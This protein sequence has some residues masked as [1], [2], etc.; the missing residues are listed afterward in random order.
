MS[1]DLLAMV[2]GADRKAY[3]G[4]LLAPAQARDDLT[5]L[6]A[7][8]VELARI[9]L[10]VTEP[11]AGE[12][13][14]QW[15]ADVIRGGRDAESAGHPVAS[16]VLAAIDRHALPREPL[17]R[18]AEARSFDL[19][20]DPMG[21]RDAFE[22]YAGETASVAIQ[23]A[24]RI[25]DPDAA[26]ASADAAGHAGVFATIVD[27]LSTVARDRASGRS[28]LPRD[29]LLEAWM[30]PD[31]VTSETLDADAAGRAVQAVAT[32]ANRH[33]AAFTGAA[34]ELPPSLAPAFA[35]AHG[36]VTDLEAMDRMG[37][38][39]FRRSAPAAP[40]REQHAV[41]RT[42]ALFAAGPGLLSGLR[43]RFGRPRS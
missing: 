7:F 22:T 39:I 26:A 42:A 4:L 19:Y 16:A 13:R 31:D 15:W 40:L 12:I 28:F 35:A 21:D 11:S 8:G 20:H 34:S 10:T 9:P 6:A 2:R 5:A 23:S 24:A 30:S 41:M 43:E 1:G 36:R 32:Y 37:A 3:L 17:A 33:R 29:V 27:R 18:M 25:L 38:E 14:F